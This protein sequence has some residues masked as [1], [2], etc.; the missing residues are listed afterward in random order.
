MGVIGG[1]VYSLSHVQLFATPQ[2]V[3]HQAPQSMG[4]PRQEHWS[5][6]PFASPEDL[7]DPG[8]KPASPA[9]AGRFSTTEPPRKSSP[10]YSFAFIRMSYKWNSVVYSFG[11]LTSFT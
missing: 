4:F 7:P 11:G 6:L 1:G 5:G 2:T 9:L 8:I 10:F 3:A